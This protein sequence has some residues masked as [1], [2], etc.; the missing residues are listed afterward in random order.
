MP[1][2]S[3]DWLK[4]LNI[5]QLLDAKIAVSMRYRPSPGAVAVPVSINSSVVA[6]WR[7]A[8]EWDAT[9]RV[10]NR[11]MPEEGPRARV[12]NRSR[13]QF[14]DWGIPESALAGISRCG[15]IEIL[16]EAYRPDTEPICVPQAEAVKE[17]DW[18][19][20]A[21]DRV[22]AM[23]AVSEVR[24]MPWESLLVMAARKY[25]NHERLLVYRRIAGLEAHKAEFVTEGSEALFVETAP[26]ALWNVYDFDFEERAVKAYLK[27]FHVER[28]RNLSLVELKA[29]IAENEFAVI[30]VSGLDGV[31]GFQILQEQVE[32]EDGASTTLAP[33]SSTAAP[34]ADATATKTAAKSTPGI[35]F[36]DEN[37]QPTIESPEKV[38]EALCAGKKKPLLVTFNVYNSSAQLAAQ[39][40][41]QG[42]AA[43]VG[44]QD[45]IDDTVADIFFAN[46]FRAWSEEPGKAL[47]DAFEV[48]VTELN[49]YI[50]RV[51]GSGVTL[52]TSENLLEDRKAICLP[53][54][55]VEPAG[56]G[57]PKAPEVELEFDIEPYRSLNYSVLHNG[58][59]KMFET[60]KIFKFG[61]GE[62][63]DVRVEVVLNVAGHNFTFRQSYQMKHHILDLTD[64]IAIGLTSALSRSLRESVRTTIF[65]RVTIG[66]DDERHC[67]TFDVS[68][69][70]VDEWIDDTQSGIFL[71]SFVLPRDPVI[72]EV[73]ARAQGYL[74]A[75]AD[76][77]AQGFDGYQSCE[78][79][80]D[81]ADALEP[82]TRA[83]WYA[84]QHDYAVKYINPPPTFT[85]SSQRLRTPSEILKGGRGTCI[86]LALL[87]AACFEAIGL[88]AVVFLLSG[89]AFAGYWTAEED[90][91]KFKT[92]KRDPTA[93]LD[94]KTFV[95][96]FEQDPQALAAEN[97]L[98]P[99]EWKYD[100][101]RLKEIREAVAEGRLVAIEATYLTNSGS[102]S[103]ACT[104][105][106][107][108]LDIAE[109]F[110]SML[111]IKMARDKDVTP[112]PLAMAAMEG[113]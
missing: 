111:D 67:E 21:L 84:L 29:Y 31:Q 98:A 88:Y 70:A 24:R 26:G 72:A 11:W 78:T 28:K 91:E 16:L 82:Q 93:E 61:G 77:A 108:N 42:A 15:R 85:E 13:K 7:A 6:F 34:A 43:A 20:G 5:W 69:L 74:M 1:L 112:L 22:W 18:S 27:G 75:I 95:N 40:V 32:N 9:M 106:A 41:R 33:A 38:A 110:D 76:D 46:L 54:L 19:K 12:E 36:R 89:H 49:P 64:G 73:I 79:A 2:F 50:E 45:Y 47:L 66:P 97:V 39:T 4:S 65:V 63:T 83:I 51:R 92:T 109:E 80:E 8:R 55:P 87:L 10:R 35:Y 94:D 107:T 44:F 56:K 30:H 86:D 17:P 60:F 71:P 58:K 105:G 96:K 52:W 53:A 25:Q 62:K 48:A 37:A 23:A 101:Q 104:E 102:F 68:L 100:A 90:Q 59:K 14:E 113:D 57:M 99:V 81:P 3:K 103:S